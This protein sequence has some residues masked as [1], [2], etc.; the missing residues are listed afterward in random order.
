[1][2]RRKLLARKTSLKPKV[3]SSRKTH[4][5]RPGEFARIYHSRERVAFVATLPCAACGR[6]EPT[7]NHN[8][9]TKSEGTGRKAGYQNIIALCP[10][11]HTKQ[12]NLGWSRVVPFDAPTTSYIN[13]WLILRAAHTERQWQDHVAGRPFYV[14]AGHAV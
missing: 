3:A 13:G 4:T 6:I 14:N 8:A 5:R 12:H 7:G 2:R 9:H 11:C 10:R 1:M